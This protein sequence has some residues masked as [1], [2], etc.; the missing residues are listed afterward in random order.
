MCLIS[1][2]AAIWLEN[3][4]GTVER[5]FMEPH[6]GYHVP[7]FLKHRLEAIT[8]AVVVETSAQEKGNTFRLEDDHERKHESF[9]NSR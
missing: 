1:G 9:E 5:L 8:D 3:P 2:E 4:A 7:P 6:R